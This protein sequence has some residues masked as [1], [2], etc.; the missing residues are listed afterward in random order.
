M[1]PR[2]ITFEGLDGSG[3]STQLEIA[4]TC[5]E[6]LRRSF[7]V[8]HEP[9]GTELGERLRSVFLDPER[10]R[11][12]GVVE[13]LVVFASR[14]QHLLEVIEPALVA[15]HDV[16]CDRFTDSTI[17]YQGFGRGVPLDT[18]MD[19]DRVATGSRRP[20]LTLI[21][22]VPAELARSRAAGSERWRQGTVDRLDREDLAFY[23]RVRDGY[24][25]TARRWP[26]RIE[27]IDASG[28]IELTASRT[29]AVLEA[30]FGG[31]GD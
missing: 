5:L 14:R 4:R 30:Y 25:E 6:S 26:E 22:D 24:L 20:D 7:V 28:D 27:L 16:V 1:P 8:T 2:F 15:G 13:A 21:L 31:D 9:G 18:L 17:A 3:K 29:R 12:D 11:L 19:L 23:E 10:Q